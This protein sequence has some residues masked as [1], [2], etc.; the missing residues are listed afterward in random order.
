MK[1]TTRTAYL[2]YVSQIAL[3]NGV[4]S[5]TQS[6]T[7]APAV[8]QTLE[9]KIQESSDF[10]KRINIMGVD[11]Q[12]GEKLG[13]GVGGPV[14]GRV[15]TSNTD[16]TT[17]DPTALT[18]NRYRCEKTNFDTHI[19][20]AKLDAWAAFPDF[21]TR[22]RDVVVQRQALDRIM[23]GF[24]GTSVAAATNAVTNPLLQDVNKG[25]LQHMR[26]DAPERV[27]T[28]GAEGSGKIVIGGD[29]A[30]A[31]YANLDALV[32][33]MVGLLD[34]WHQ[35]DTSLVVIV[36]R[37]LLADKYFPLINKD[38]PATEQLATDVV[39]SQKRVGGLPAVRVPFFP[40]DGILVT[41][42]DNLSI[43][44]QKGA[45]RRHV[46]DNP[47]RDQV[48]NYESSND[49]YVVE[50]Y[51]KAAFAENIEQGVPAAG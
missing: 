13:L 27:M 50:D 44:Y 51:G 49:A 9:T 47:K 33:D 5:A 11:E 21:Q 22:V 43:Y 10:L 19:K 23:I 3:L 31:D 16:R 12:E 39:V 29:P 24:N 4:A 25:W 7:V 14:A 18:A 42:L 37:Q 28:E 35:E 34:P 6:F 32:Y 20:Y 40:A 17:K 2:A 38:Q 48:E 36:G 46:L 41:T 8:Q 15:D 1:N 45:R 26:E 30:A